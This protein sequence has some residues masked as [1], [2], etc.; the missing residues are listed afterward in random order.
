LMAENRGKIDASAGQRFLSDHYDTFAKKEDPNERTLCGHIDLSP[1]GSLPWQPPF[2]IAGAVHAKVMDASMAER[3]SLVASA[4]HSCG[5]HFKAAQHLRGHPEFAWQKA[6][7]HDMN[8][9]PWTT[10]HAE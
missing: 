3:L 5:L 7:L 6:Y 1:R 9:Q 4:G 2:G 10:F 8:S